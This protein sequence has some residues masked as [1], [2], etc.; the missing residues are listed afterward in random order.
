MHRQITGIS[1]QPEKEISVIHVIAAEALF[2]G[3]FT[4][5]EEA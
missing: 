5:R 3:T 2:G 1:C 4:H